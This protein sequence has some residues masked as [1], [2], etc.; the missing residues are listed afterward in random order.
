MTAYRLR[1]RFSVYMPGVIESS[2]RQLEF[3]VLSSRVVALND[4]RERSISES[5]RLIFSSGEFGAESEALEFGDKLKTAVLATAVRHRIGV[6]VGKDKSRGGA[7]RYLKEKVREK[8]GVQLLNDIHG[9]MVYP[10]QP[11]ARIMSVSPGRVYTPL[12]AADF[13]QDI[14][15]FLESDLQVSDKEKLSMELYGASYYET[16]DRTRF[17]VLPNSHGQT[18]RK[19]FRFTRTR[20]GDKNRETMNPPPERTAGKSAKED[21]RCDTKISRDEVH[22]SYAETREKEASRRWRDGGSRISKSFWSTAGDKHHF[23]QAVQNP[24]S[25]FAP[26]C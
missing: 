20:T 19:R 24:R 8:C 7:T 9:V 26:A 4:A 2:E 12:Q 6:D 18:R 14:V 22:G 25:R 11:P 3:L 5:D 1:F 17:P 21:G 16:S 23:G 10:D 15:R 13:V